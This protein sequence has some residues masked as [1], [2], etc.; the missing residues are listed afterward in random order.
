M[1]FGVCTMNDLHFTIMNIVTTNIITTTSDLIWVC[2]ELEEEHDN[3]LVCQ[4]VFVIH[5]L[6]SFRSYQPNR[7][8]MIG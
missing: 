5:R 8:L 3:A 4:V 1:H 2:N 6:H 7:R